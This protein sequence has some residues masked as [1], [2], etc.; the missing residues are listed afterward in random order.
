MRIA[1][2]LKTIEAINHLS[3]SITGKYPPNTFQI[4]QT[5]VTSAKE[6]KHKLRSQQENLLGWVG[7]GVQPSLRPRDAAPESHRIETH[8][9]LSHSQPWLDSTWTRGEAQENVA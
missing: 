9:G 8:G 5:T 2:N 7:M 3:L 1:F 4:F 6:N